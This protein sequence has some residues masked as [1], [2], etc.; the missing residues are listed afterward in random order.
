MLSEDGFQVTYG[1][2]NLSTFSLCIV[3]ASTN[4]QEKRLV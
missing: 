4:L 3:H 1:S 2:I